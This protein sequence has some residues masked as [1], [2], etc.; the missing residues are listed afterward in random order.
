MLPNMTEE[1]NPLK[2]RLLGSEY[3][4]FELGEK[5][6]SIEKA[7]SKPTSQRMRQLN[8]KSTGSKT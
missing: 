1:L 8:I 7:L 5:N 2:P 3:Q 4:K 6:E